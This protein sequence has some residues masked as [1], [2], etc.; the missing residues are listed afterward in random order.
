MGLPEENKE[1]YKKSSTLYDVTNL[2]KKKYFLIHGNADDNVH[3]QNAMML[4]R[5]LEKKNIPFELMVRNNNNILRTLS[6]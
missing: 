2:L 6:L 3:Y 4:A 1:G 5:V